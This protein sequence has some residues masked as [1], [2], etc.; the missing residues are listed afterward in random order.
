MKQCLTVKSSNLDNPLKSFKFFIAF[1]TLVAQPIE[2]AHYIIHGIK[3][4]LAKNVEHRLSVFEKSKYPPQETTLINNI[5]LAM[6]PFG[7]YTPQIH[8]E[9]QKIFI[10]Q[11]SPTRIHAI[12]IVIEGPG[13]AT[14][15]AELSRLPL[16]KGNVFDS[17]KFEQSKQLLFDLA[18]QDGYLNAR[19]IH[20]EAI[21]N[22]EHHSADILI[23]FH[24]GDL[25][26]FGVIKFDPDTA[27]AHA[28]LNR[29]VQIKPGDPFDTDKLLTLNASLNDSGYFQSVS[30]KPQIN[31]QTNV[32]VDIYL[33]DKPSQNYIVGL[34]YVTDSGP[35]A[36][37]GWNW[38]RVNDYGHTFQAMY[39]GSYSQNVLQAQYVI[40]GPIPS[41]DQ[42]VFSSKVFQLNY[43]IGLS[44]AQLFSA[45]SVFE[46]NKRQVT[47]S[48][49]ALNETSQFL[50]SDKLTRQVIYPDL[51]IS[52]KQISS[53]LFSK[54]GFSL[55]ANTKIARKN[56][57]S[58]LNLSQIE[59]AAKAAVW[60][61]THTRF[62]VRGQFGFTDTDDIYQL[63]LSLQLLAGGADSVR[64]YH[65]QGIGP[66]EKLAVG[67][68][69][70]Q[71]ETPFENWFITAFY[72]IGNVHK[73]NP[74][75]WHRGVGGGLMWVSPIGPIRLSVAKA[76][77]ENSQPFRIVF[78]MG[79]DL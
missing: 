15:Q 31:D 72:D 53:P 75:Y 78:N 14:L 54:Q 62:F 17:E 30:V 43:P 19:M 20:S 24:T 56:L 67:S 38:L 33:L 18:E 49:N 28:F 60:L 47:L 66:G 22:P 13:N 45:S 61:P 59:L 63:P 4:E 42:Y 68:A 39:V 50:Y 57:G 34:G 21:V 16:K 55:L 37:V 69:E 46:R 48:L 71:Q 27:Y 44:R 65:Y 77:D 36:R 10:Q 26:H 5:K 8:I 3:G 51:K 74:S 79:P 7:Y 2:A 29:Y 70:I 23:H 1:C 52:Y 35:R 76:L 25:Y 9:K 40:P 41:T 32:P 58:D 12:N 11:G 6:A 64:G 73:P